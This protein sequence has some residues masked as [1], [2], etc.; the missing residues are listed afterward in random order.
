MSSKKELTPKQELFCREYIKDLN[1]KRAA[2]RAKYSPAT[3]QYSSS[4]LL[5]YDKVAHRI[6]ELMDQREKRLEIK[7]DDVLDEIRKLALSDLRKVFDEQGKLLPP[8]QWPD[9]VA[10]AVSSVEVDELFEGVGRE[11]KQIGFTKKVKFWN[12]GHAL[13]MLA[14]HLSLFNDKL[15]VEIPTPADPY[16]DYSEEDLKAMREIHSRNQKNQIE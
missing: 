11:R 9:D 8:D 1:A 12:K 13:E 15:K 16:K 2:V 14:R 10:M 7:A 5:T 3:A 4:R 6:K